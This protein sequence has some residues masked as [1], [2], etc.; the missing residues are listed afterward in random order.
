MNI[1]GPVIIV[2]MVTFHSVSTLNLNNVFHLCTLRMNSYV[3][4]YVIKAADY[5]FTIQDNQSGLNTVTLFDVI[6]CFI[7]LKKYNFE[8]NLLTFN[9]PLNSKTSGATTHYSLAKTTIP[10]EHMAG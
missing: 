1:E 10:C 6:R 4:G 7:T 2:M 3:T 5:H 9:R 8:S